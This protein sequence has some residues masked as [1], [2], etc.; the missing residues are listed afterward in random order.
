M[1]KRLL[2]VILLVVL[3][4]TSCNFP[5]AAL[6]REDQPLYVPPTGQTLAPPATVTPDPSARIKLGDEVILPL[7]S[8]A[9]FPLARLDDSGQP[10]ILSLGD[11]KAV[12]NNADETL[13]FSIASEPAGTNPDAAACLAK[14]LARM[15]ADLPDLSASPAAE[16]AAYW[17]AGL[18][19]E[20][21]GT[22]LGAPMAG[23]LAVFQVQSRCVSLLGAAALENPQALWLETGQYAFQA[24]LGGL[25]ALPPGS[26]PACLI[27]SDPEYAF[28]PENPIR[29][30]SVNMYDG[31][32]RMEAYLNTLRGPNLEEISYIRLN[33]QYNADEEI[34][35]AY[36]ISYAGSGDPITIYFSIYSYETLLAP[37][38]F[39]CEAAFP[40]RQP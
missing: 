1:K 38:G 24:L 37:L 36:Q 32:A 8:L 30:G 33:P 35:D 5:S 27:A 6:P 28:S 29:V 22:L 21:S 39:S 20:I 16:I 17:M 18:Q 12:M 4:V 23:R 11:D 31:I 15:Q 40:L 7:G 26:A 9:F 10:V 2:A 34:V 3:L 19:T 14:L 13:F 25:R